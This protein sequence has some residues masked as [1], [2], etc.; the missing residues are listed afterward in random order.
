MVDA[1]RKLIDDAGLDQ[2][3]HAALKVA[4]GTHDPVV[5]DTQV[6]D[7]HRDAAGRDPLE[8]AARQRITG[9]EGPP[10]VDPGEQLLDGGHHRH[11]VAG[12]WRTIDDVAHLRALRVREVEHRCRRHLRKPR[13]AELG[14]GLA[15][16]W[17]DMASLVMP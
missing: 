5:V 11:G 13:R 12:P 3:E 9:L 8:A 15:P 17:L 10:V 4:G 1:L 6:L 16:T 14:T 7:D 2:R